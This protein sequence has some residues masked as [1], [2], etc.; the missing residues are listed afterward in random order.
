MKILHLDEI[1]KILNQVNPIR[2]IEQGFVLYSRDKATVPPVG[3]LLMPKGEAHIKYGCINNDEFYTIKIASGFYQNTELG[4]P[5]SN[6]LMLLFSQKTG[7]LQCILLDQGYLTDI[8]TAVAGAIAAKWL[9]PTKV[10]S[11]G[12]IGTGIQARLQAIYLKQVTECRNLT[13]WGRDAEKTQ[14]YKQDIEKQGFTVK[15]TESI[16]EL[17]YQSNLIVTTTPSTEPLLFA[18]MIQHGTHITAMGSD[19]PDKQ[20]LDSQILIN[21][22]LVISDS[23]S[24]S[25]HR[26]EIYQARNSNDFD[27]DK[28]IELGNI[29]DSKSG[30]QNNQQTTVADLT[31]VAVQDIKIAELI[32]NG[33][34]MN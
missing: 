23:I 9:A 11:I 14:A 29:I 10:N 21:A 6:G 5:N 3:E 19:T 22:D 7:E 4:L 2:E 17:A 28:V 8:R 13:V 33:H 27:T 26:G 32:Y 16:E 18:D 24:Q 12:I 1:K 30:R 25:Q 15:V 34:R 20:E 31:G